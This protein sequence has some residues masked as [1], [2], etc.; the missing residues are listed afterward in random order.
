M[1]MKEQ[2]EFVRRQGKMP[3]AATFPGAPA[4]VRCTIDDISSVGARLAF[5]GPVAIPE[6]FDLRI[7]ATGEAY[8]VE[9]RWQRGLEI[10]VRFLDA[11][12]PAPTA[13][14]NGE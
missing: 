14:S 10:G 8:R 7:I 12:K 2:R 4:P 3:A 11:A 9:R 5:S 6:A 13:R 1:A